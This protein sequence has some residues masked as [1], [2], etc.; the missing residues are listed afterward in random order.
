[1]L[2]EA[3]SCSSLVKPMSLSLLGVSKSNLMLV[4]QSSSLDFWG[5]SLQADLLPELSEVPPNCSL[6][7]VLWSTFSVAFWRGKAAGTGWEWVQCCCGLRGGSC[8][9]W[10]QN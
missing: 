9:M 10:L 8:S 2:P 7:H 5:D 4:S 1:M 3:G 6:V